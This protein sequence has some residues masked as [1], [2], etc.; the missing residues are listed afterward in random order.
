VIVVEYP[1]PV[2]INNIHHMEDQFYLT[3]RSHRFV[4]HIYS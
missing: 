4:H 3:H 1:D 2:L